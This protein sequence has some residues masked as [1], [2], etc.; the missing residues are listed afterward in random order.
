MLSSSILILFLSIVE[1]LRTP[2]LVD[3]ASKQGHLGLHGGKA[4]L[5]EA[6]HLRIQRLERRKEIIHYMQYNL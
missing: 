4:A 2:C 1:G 5:L 3:L 6:P